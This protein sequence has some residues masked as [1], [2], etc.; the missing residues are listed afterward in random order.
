MWKFITKD[1]TTY[2]TCLVTA[3]HIWY[4]NSRP[5]KHIFCSAKT[6]T[7]FPHMAHNLLH[8]LNM[9][10]W[11]QSSISQFCYQRWQVK[12]T[13]GEYN[14]SISNKKLTSVKCVCESPFFLISQQVSKQCTLS[15]QYLHIL[16]DG[17]SIK[18]KMHTITFLQAF[19][20]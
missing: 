13:S 9:N 16:K 20:F 10:F 17:I 11:R 7:L 4:Y 6:E 12:Q 2:E 18:H 14:T 5:N 19:F 1:V 8:F 3:C 15:A